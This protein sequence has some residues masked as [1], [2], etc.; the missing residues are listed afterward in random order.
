MFSPTLISLATTVLD[1]ARA[2][3][4]R[5]TTAESCTGG[6]IAGLL[7]E[8][9]G[10]SDVLECGFVAYS[11]Q[12]KQDLLGIPGNLIAK[13]GAVSSA[14]AQ[15]MA[16][17]AAAHS[18]TQLA[19]AVTGIAGPGGGTAQKPVGLVHFAAYREGGA[20]LHQE[21]RF[22]DIGRAH[23]RLKSV[24]TALTLLRQLI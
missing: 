5:I 7:T 9:P 20:I 23:V 24:E 2:K 12:A 4:M 17:G 16:Q 1:E 3:G 15:A 6:L 21:R 19:V 14:V 8:I 18:K 11:D 22:G 10:S 13:H